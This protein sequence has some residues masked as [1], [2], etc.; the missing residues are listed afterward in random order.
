MPF[1]IFLRMSGCSRASRV[2]RYTFGHILTILL[3]IFGHFWK[4]FKPIW[5]IIFIFGDIRTLHLYILSPFNS[6]P[7][8]CWI[9]TKVQIKAIEIAPIKKNNFFSTFGAFSW[10]SKNCPNFGAFGFVSLPNHHLPPNN[11]EHL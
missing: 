2:A 6:L 7:I 10:K 11:Y 5:K 3:Y 1:S 8:S 9:T 4:L